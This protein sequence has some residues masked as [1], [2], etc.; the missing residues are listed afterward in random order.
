[1]NL[2]VR[3]SKHEVLLALKA[4]FGIAFSNSSTLSV[5]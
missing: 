2:S 1:M 5:S 3:I 4:V